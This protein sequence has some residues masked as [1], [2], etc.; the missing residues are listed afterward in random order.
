MITCR[1]LPAEGGVVSLHGLR[2]AEDATE[3][4]KKPSLLDGTDRM[5]VDVYGEVRTRYRSC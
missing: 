5:K 4:R 3:R 2:F 1:S